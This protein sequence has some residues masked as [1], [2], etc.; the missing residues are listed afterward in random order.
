MT[1][2]E[3]RSIEKT[4][5]ASIISELKLVLDQNS[6]NLS[7]LKE[8]ILELA[9]MFDETGTIQKGKISSKIKKVLQEEIKAGKITKR[10]IHGCLPSDYKRLYNKRERNSLSNFQS[11]N[12]WLMQDI[13]KG[14]D[15]QNPDRILDMYVPIPIGQLQNFCM[16]FSSLGEEDLWFWV[17][18]DLDTGKLLTFT[19]GMNEFVKSIG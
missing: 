6:S 4:E 9:R 17:R 2:D 5:V 8:L 13:P 14:E 7:H 1:H 16:L 19:F 18:A 3:T 12:D 10:W 11:Q 15:L